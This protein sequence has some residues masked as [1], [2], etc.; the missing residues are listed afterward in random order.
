MSTDV[1]TRTWHKA[2]GAIAALAL[3]V[4]ACGGDDDSADDAIDDTAEE[5][6]EDTGTGTADDTTDTV[7]AVQGGSVLA[8]VQIVACSTVAATTP[9]PASARSTPRPV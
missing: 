7:D 6:A 4:S 9:W 8:A 1:T 3:V 2:A 5:T